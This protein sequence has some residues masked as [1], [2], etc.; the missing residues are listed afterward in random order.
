MPHLEPFFW[1]VWD[2]EQV[3]ELYESTGT[4]NTRNDRERK[5]EFVLFDYRRRNPLNSEAETCHVVCRQT[6]N[7]V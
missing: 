2:R 6:E 4:E 3:A 7:E 1:P 5:A